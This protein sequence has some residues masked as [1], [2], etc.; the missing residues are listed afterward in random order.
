MKLVPQWKQAFKWFSVQAH[1]AQ[2]AIVGTWTTL[3][4]DMR[5][6]VPVRFVLVAVAVVGA[7]GVIG[8]LVNQEKPDA[9][10][11]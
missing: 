10:P 11:H 1:V 9:D 4:D 2:V 6:A 7:A 8:R 3:P 5:S